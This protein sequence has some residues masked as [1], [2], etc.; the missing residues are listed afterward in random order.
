MRNYSNSSKK[1]WPLRRMRNKCAAIFNLDLSS[2]KYSIATMNRYNL[3][4]ACFVVTLFFAF[5]QYSS[6]DLQTKS[7]LLGEQYQ[8]ARKQGLA[9]LNDQYLILFRKEL[10][11]AMSARKLEDANAIQKLI[12]KLEKE[13]IELQRKPEQPEKEFSILKKVLFFPHERQADFTVRV[14]FKKNGEAI[15]IGLGNVEA[16]WVYEKGDKPLVYFFGG[17]RL[18]RVDVNPDGKTATVTK[19]GTPYRVEAKIKR[20]R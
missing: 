6:A 3:P 14:E 20:S 15:W 9:R 12:D 8:K 1:S 17:N 2:P 16:N 5:P 7:E 4:L 18:Y 10:A 19:K 13:N 11:K